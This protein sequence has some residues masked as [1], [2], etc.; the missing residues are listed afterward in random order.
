MPKYRLTGTEVFQAGFGGAPTTYTQV[1]KVFRAKKDQDAVEKV[2]KLIDKWDDELGLGSHISVDESDQYF[3]SNGMKCGIN[4]EWKPVSLVRIDREV[5]A[6]IT[7]KIPFP[8]KMLA[9]F[10]SE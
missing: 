1:S 10:S 9:K 3:W 7:T 4:H 8:K 2:P 6:E 5:I